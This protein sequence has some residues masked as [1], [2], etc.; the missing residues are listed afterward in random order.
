M[1]EMLLHQQ[2]DS[3]TQPAYCV[4]RVINT[5]H[6]PAD[7]TMA[8]KLKRHFHNT[9]AVIPVGKEVYGKTT[10]AFLVHNL[11]SDGEDWL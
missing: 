9:Y 3:I 1:Q 4:I 2:E 11:R 5:E 7:G 10:D 8:N 6:R